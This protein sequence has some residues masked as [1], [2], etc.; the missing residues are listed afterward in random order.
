MLPIEGSK[1]MEIKQDSP[2]TL[3]HNMTNPTTSFNIFVKKVI[4]LVSLTHSIV[5]FG[6]KKV[7]EIGP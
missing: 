5:T 3:I 6:P 4:K 1:Q 7:Q 2:G